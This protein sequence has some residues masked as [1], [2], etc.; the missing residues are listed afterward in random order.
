MLRL[1]SGAELAVLQERTAGAARAK[2]QPCSALEG[3]ALPPV[4]DNFSV[5]RRRPGCPD[6]GHVAAHIRTKSRANLL[7]PSTVPLPAPISSGDGCVSAGGAD[8]ATLR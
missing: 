5:E 2:H 7:G 3:R 8:S 4:Q 1:D 6:S